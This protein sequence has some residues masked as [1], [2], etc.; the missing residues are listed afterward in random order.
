M[1]ELLRFL[2]QVIVILT[3]S[4]LVGAVLDRWGQPRVIG[5]ILAGI[6]L[7]PSFLGW[8]APAIWVRIFRQPVCLY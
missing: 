3:V 8:L 5:E 2:I 7:G 6:L 4:H 1:S